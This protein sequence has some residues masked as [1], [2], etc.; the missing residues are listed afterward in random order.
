MPLE[1]IYESPNLVDLNMN[2]N[3]ERMHLMG[4]GCHNVKVHIPFLIL[5]S[6]ELYLPKSPQIVKKLATIC[7]ISTKCPK[8]QP[9][10]IGV[11]RNQLEKEVE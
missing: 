1:T 2:K 9:H 7:R 10:R 6:P 4:I 3:W 8:I 11:W 5:Q